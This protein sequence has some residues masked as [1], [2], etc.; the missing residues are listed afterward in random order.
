MLDSEEQVQ[1]RLPI[2]LPK[3]KFGSSGDSDKETYK[4]DAA[5][6]PCAGDPEDDNPKVSSSST[7]FLADQIQVLTTRFDTY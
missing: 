3:A 4:D 5:A 2:P 6:T 7:Q 1:Q